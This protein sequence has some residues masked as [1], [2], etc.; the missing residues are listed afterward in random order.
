MNAELDA[1]QH[2]TMQLGI[3]HALESLLAKKE[4]SQIKVNEICAE[5]HV[6]K[7]TFYRYFSSKEHIV[8]WL[9]QHSLDCGVVRIGRDLSWH[10]GFLKTNTMHYQ[11]RIFY[12]SNTRTSGIPETLLSFSSSYFAKALAQTLIS[13]GI[14]ITNRLAYQI[15]F[16]T[17]GTGHIS[18][19]WA[20]EGM[21]IDLNTFADIEESMVPSELKA[22]LP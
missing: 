15:D 18:K 13:K 4:Y 8:I 16:F 19:R 10:E 11:R 22:L 21:R 12:E 1:E 17:L 5:A 2:V 7:T 20:A 9:A 14:N 6:S 3:L